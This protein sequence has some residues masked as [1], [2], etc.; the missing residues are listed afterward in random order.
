MVFENCSACSLKN[1]QTGNSTSDYEALRFAFHFFFFF[2]IYF[3]IRIP[4]SWA[5]ILA[6]TCLEISILINTLFLIIALHN[7]FLF[8]FFFT[9]DIATRSDPKSSELPI[10]P[11]SAIGRNTH[12]LLQI[13][14]QTR[15]IKMFIKYSRTHT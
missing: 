13:L 6:Y 12:C 10:S 2:L 14:P 9:K 5:S 7:F 8:I 11:F 15:K 1:R 4:I 3:S